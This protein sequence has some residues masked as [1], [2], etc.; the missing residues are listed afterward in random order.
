MWRLGETEP[1]ATRPL[2]PREREHRHDAHGL[3]KAPLLA[4]TG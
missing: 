3:G 2:Q 4:L 1:R